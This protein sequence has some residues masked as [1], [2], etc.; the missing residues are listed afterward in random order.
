M[1][2]QSTLP[3]QVQAVR[4]K[5]KA[6]KEELE[7]WEEKNAASRNEGTLHGILDHHPYASVTQV[8]YTTPQ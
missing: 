5:L 1:S 6:D 8:I 7:E 3:S 4:D 2:E